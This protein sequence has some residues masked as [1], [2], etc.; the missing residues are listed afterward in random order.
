MDAKITLAHIVAAALLREVI[1]RR[2]NGISQTS[3]ESKALLKMVHLLA[4]PGQVV[5]YEDGRAKLLGDTSG[6]TF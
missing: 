6:V 1:R 5:V 2:K 3:A 4:A